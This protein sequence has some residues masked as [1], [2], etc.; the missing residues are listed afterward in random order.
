M[1]IADFNNDSIQKLLKFL[2]ENIGIVPEDCV[3]C[4]KD[5]VNILEPPKI[6]FKNSKRIS[7]KIL[8]SSSCIF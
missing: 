5:I 7:S 2:E 1:E 3:A 4:S 8:S 6:Y